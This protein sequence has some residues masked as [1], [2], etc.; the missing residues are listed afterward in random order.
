[1]G[2]MLFSAIDAGTPCLHPRIYRFSLIPR[3]TTDD[4]VICLV[5]DLAIAVFVKTGCMGMSGIHVGL[6][7]ALNVEH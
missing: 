4:D 1:M 5:M 2:L 3:P 7:S 6:Q